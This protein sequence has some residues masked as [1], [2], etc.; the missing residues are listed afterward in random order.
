M[1]L[2]RSNRGQRAQHNLLCKV[3]IDIEQRVGDQLHPQFF[4][5]MHDLK[6]QLVL[7]AQ[8]LEW[9]LA[10][11]Q[12]F[13]VEINFVVQSIAAVHLRVKGLPVHKLSS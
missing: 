9:L 11:E 5:L 12:I 6:L 1:R 7:V 10:G 13:R 8:L 2:Q 4:N 3:F